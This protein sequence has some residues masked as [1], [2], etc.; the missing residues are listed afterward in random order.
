MINRGF[1][2]SINAYDINYDNYAPNYSFK[3]TNT[4]TIGRGGF[5]ITAGDGDDS[6]ENFGTIVGNVN[7]GP[8]N[9]VFN[10][11]QG[12]FTGVVRGG[13]GN[14]HLSGNAAA[15]DL[16]GDAG[17]DILQGGR[18]DDI[19]NGGAGADRMVGGRGND[20]YYVNEAGDRVVEGL[21]GAAG[22]RDTV[23]ASVSFRLPDHVEVLF[24]TG[25]ANINGTGNA[26]AN[27]ISGNRGINALRGMDGDDV[28]QSG[29]G[30]DVLIGGRGRDVFK[31]TGINGST[32]AAPDRIAA[33][34]GAV[35]F[36]L[37]GRGLGDRIDLSAIDAN[38]LLA[39]KQD[40][41]FGSAKGIGRL[42]AVNVGEVTMIRGNVDARPG[43]ELQIA[44]LDGWVD[45]S[46]YT[47]DDFI[48]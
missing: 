30:A 20:T 42:W 24:L 23:H 47:R 11:S 17:D 13:A 34:N 3:I 43:P 2:L 36:E 40:F 33:G 22:G 14:D 37:P 27:A 5:A 48:L 9:D 15:N 21:G 16:R 19:L 7:L 46:A 26:L 29:G 45:A 44:I 39:G 31:Y 25:K 32:P 1:I 38:A 6:V 10:T 12:V 28:I 18:G 41:V 8:G 35:A 4:G